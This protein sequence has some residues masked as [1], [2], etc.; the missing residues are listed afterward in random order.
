LIPF[1]ITHF[2]YFIDFISDD[3]HFIISPVDLT[4]IIILNCCI[5]D[6]FFDIHHRFIF[7]FEFDHQMLLLPFQVFSPN[8]CTKLLSILFFIFLI[9]T[10]IKTRFNSIFTILYAYLI[11]A[12]A[13]NFLIVIM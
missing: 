10:S 8:L 6:L 4:R 1:N 5:F 9:N 11:I 13:T 2:L 7:L 3:A 12:C